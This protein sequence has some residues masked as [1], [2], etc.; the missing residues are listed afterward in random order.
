VTARSRIAAA[1]R[2][3]AVRLQRASER[4]CIRERPDAAL[5]ERLQR[6]VQEVRS[7]RTD[8]RT[9]HPEGPWRARELRSDARRRSR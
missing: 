8:Y 1:I 9:A 2:K 6:R 3:T 7:A 4:S 5:G